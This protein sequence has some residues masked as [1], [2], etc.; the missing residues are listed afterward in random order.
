ML[1]CFFG[2]SSRAKCLDNIFDFLSAYGAEG[3]TFLFHSQS[4]FKTHT[5]VTAGVEYRVYWT[6]IT[7]VALVALIVYDRTVIG[8]RAIYG[9]QAGV[10]S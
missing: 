3:T 10:E 5:H 4:T 8:G 1:L 6:F 2:N 9:S 7:D